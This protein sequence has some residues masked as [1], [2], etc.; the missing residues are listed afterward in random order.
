MQV[1]ILIAF[2]LVLCTTS[3]DSKDDFGGIKTN[4]E[5]LKKNCKKMTTEF[6]KY[7]QNTTRKDFLVEVNKLCNDERGLTEFKYPTL[8]NGLN[9]KLI[10]L[11]SNLCARER[12]S[13]IKSN[14]IEMAIE[15]WKYFITS[16]LVKELALIYENCDE[17]AILCYGLDENFINLSSGL[18]GDLSGKTVL[19]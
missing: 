13:N 7:F 4:E 16:D 6:W 12:A 10:H 9:D 8:C 15:F 19:H 17:Y 2:F 1:V 18:C 5:Q 11:S 3:I 14:C